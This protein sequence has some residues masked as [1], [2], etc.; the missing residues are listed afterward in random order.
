MNVATQ[1]RIRDTI[2]SE[3]FSTTFKER[4]LAVNIQGA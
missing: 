1:E 3:T 4:V 2:R